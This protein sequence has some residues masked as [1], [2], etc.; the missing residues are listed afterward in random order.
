MCRSIYIFKISIIRLCWLY[1]AAVPDFEFAPLPV[2]SAGDTHALGSGVCSMCVCVH[3]CVGVSLPSLSNLLETQ[4]CV[5]VCVYVYKCM[6]V[7]AYVCVCVCV[8]MRVYAY[9]YICVVC[10]R[11]IRVCVCACVY[12]YTCVWVCRCMCLYVYIYICVYVHG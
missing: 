8:C 9:I 11:H 7:C 1:L 10:W 6:C 3:V 2:E 5:C 4:K 12:M